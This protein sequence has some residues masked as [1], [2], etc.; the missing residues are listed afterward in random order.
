MTKETDFSAVD[1][2]IL[3]LLNNQPMSAY[4]L[5]K[6]QGIY[7]L[8]KISKPAVYKNVHKLCERGHLEGRVSKS[9]NMPEKT[10]YTVTKAGQQHIQDLLEGSI[11]H[12]VKF[13]FDF[14]GLILLIEQLPKSEAIRLL[15]GLMQSLRENKRYLHEEAAQYSFLPFN[16][17][18]LANQ[19]IMLNDT[20][21]KWLDGFMEEFMRT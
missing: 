1:L 16:V 15:N 19:H 9:G 11:S 7:E 3:G 4:D 10:V 6:L 20:L 5:A 14:N 18:A 21:I 2:V 13:H 8:V 12:R 17:Q